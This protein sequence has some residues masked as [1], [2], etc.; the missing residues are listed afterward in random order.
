MELEFRTSSLYTMFLKPAEGVRS[1]RKGR[2][3]G[4]KGKKGIDEAAQG[5][6]VQEGDQ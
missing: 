4:K 6:G 3:S 1:P 5:E 2:R